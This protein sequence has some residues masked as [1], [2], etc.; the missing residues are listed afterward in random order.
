MVGA[1]RRLGPPLG[2]RAVRQLMGLG[3]LGV[4]P[5]MA[6]LWWLV[7]LWS[8]NALCMIQDFLKNLTSYPRSEGSV[9][10]IKYRW[11]TEIRRLVL[12]AKEGVHDK[13][14]EV[15]S[16]AHTAWSVPGKKR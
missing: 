15:A 7:A 6:A 1:W 11:R 14:V 8:R 9:F 2:D 5:E 3:K 10:P 13:E 4:Q 16:P 12:H